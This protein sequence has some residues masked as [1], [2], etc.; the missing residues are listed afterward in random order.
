MTTRGK[1]CVAVRKEKDSSVT[2]AVR[3]HA[4]G[5]RREIQ[6]VRD[7]RLCVRTTAPPVGGKA[8]KDVARQLAR[9]FGVPPSCVSLKSGAT[10]RNKIFSI[11][12]P[13]VLPPWIAE[14]LENR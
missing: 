6:G 1:Y 4:R 2:I 12:S 13:A 3:V 11:S 14:V 5:S 9:E 8:N 7:G 10:G